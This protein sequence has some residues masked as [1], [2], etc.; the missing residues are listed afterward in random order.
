[1][2]IYFSDVKFCSL[3][4]A[5]PRERNRK[6]PIYGCFCTNVPILRSMRS[7]RSMNF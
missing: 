5:F 7:M 1:M 4:K 6:I 3:E 2:I